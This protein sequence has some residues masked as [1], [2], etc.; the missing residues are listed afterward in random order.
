MRR[1]PK[2]T[3]A[4]AGHG[5][6][7]APASSEATNHRSFPATGLVFEAIAQ[8]IAHRGFAVAPDALPLALV[9]R[10][11]GEA[12]ARRRAGELKTAGV[13]RARSFRIDSAVRSDCIAWLDPQ[14]ARPAERRYLTLMERLRA[15]LNRSLLLG[16]FDFEGHH[17]C[18]PS[19]GYYR[20]HRDRHSGSDARVLSVVCYLNEGWREEEGGALRIYPETASTDPETP[21]APVDV[22][23]CAGTLVC[24]LCGTLE[25]EVLPAT[26][27]RYS[28]S[29]WFR[30]RT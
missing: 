14:R 16:L 13:G 2:P 30:R 24:F 5:S 29:G 22:T 11:H 20:R 28:L 27:E 3:D 4:R 26:R 7:G 18:Y 17:A 6:Q 25:H 19:G 12:V 21:S 1:Q 23:P 15:M 10:L 9:R 8:A